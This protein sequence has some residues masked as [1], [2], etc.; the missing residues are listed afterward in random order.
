MGPKI[1]FDYYFSKLGSLHKVDLELWGSENPEMVINKFI[2]ENNA[3]YIW[4]ISQ[5][6]SWDDT[7]IKKYLEKSFLLVRKENIFSN[8][9]MGFEIYLY[10]IP[11]TEVDP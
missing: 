4:Y 7:G 9:T 11:K 8:D 2:T 5:R 1:G 10:S 6:Y 3:S